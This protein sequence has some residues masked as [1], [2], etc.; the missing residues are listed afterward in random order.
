M[1]ARADLFRLRDH[2]T[3]AFHTASDRATRERAL[4]LHLKINARLL[5]GWTAFPQGWAEGSFA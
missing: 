5:R 1:F 3:E 4:A 2:L